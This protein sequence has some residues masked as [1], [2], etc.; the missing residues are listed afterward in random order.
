MA[1]NIPTLVDP[2]VKAVG[3]IGPGAVC[4]IYSD[5]RNR[6]DIEQLAHAFDEFFNLERLVHEVVGPSSFQFTDFVF[7]NHTRDADDPTSSIDLS[8]RTRWQTSL[9]R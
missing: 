9:A 4:L 1:R 3:S 6:F 2:T 7:F 8:L 5:A